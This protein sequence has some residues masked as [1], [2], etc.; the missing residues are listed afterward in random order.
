VSPCVPNRLVIESTTPGT[1]FGESN[2]YRVCPVCGDR[3]LV[4]HFNTPDHRCH[5]EVFVETMERQESPK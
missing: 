1:A 2:V 3:R 4:A 5:A